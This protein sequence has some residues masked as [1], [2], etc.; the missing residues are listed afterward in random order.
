MWQC[1]VANGKGMLTGKPKIK[2][3]QQYIQFDYP[4]M[5]T[6]VSGYY[7][8]IDMHYLPGIMYVILSNMVESAPQNSKVC[9]D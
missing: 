2:K 1:D 4:A 5:H 3:H 7:L 9:K 8:C 6:I